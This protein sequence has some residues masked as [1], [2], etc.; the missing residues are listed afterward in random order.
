MYKAHS[1]RAHLG[2][3]VP[4]LKRDPDKLSI[5]VKDGRVVCAGEASLSFEYAFTLQIIVLDYAGHADAITLPILVWM[6]THQPEYFDNPAQRDKAFRFEA[7]YNNAKTIDLAIELDL[8]ERVRV[9]HADI[10]D[11]LPPGRYNVSHL[12]EPNRPGTLDP[13]EHWEF[14]LRDQMLAEWTW[15]PL[16][17]DQAPWLEA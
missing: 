13:V 4:D 2:A 10:S 17:L 15:N 1:L 14:W 5:L 12:P 11:T 3:T 8:T 7:E 6:R 9:S 16:E